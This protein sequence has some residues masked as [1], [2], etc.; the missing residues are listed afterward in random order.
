MKGPSLM[1]VR[2][3]IFK[4]S[5]HVTNSIQGYNNPELNAK[6]FDADGYFRTG[7]LFTVNEK[8]EFFYIN[9]IKDVIKYKYHYVSIG[10]QHDVQRNVLIVFFL[11]RSLPK[12]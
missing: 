7:D 4:T 1:P 12:R 11:I 10:P 8:G 2:K 3:N 9:R 6:A 5:L